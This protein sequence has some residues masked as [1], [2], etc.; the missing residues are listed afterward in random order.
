MKNSMPNEPPP[1]RASTSGATEQAEA[2]RT[3][4]SPASGAGHFELP[5]LCSPLAALGVVLGS[6]LLALLLTLARAPA[7]SDFYT[8]L[9]RAALLLLWT[10]LVCAALLCML[11]PRLARLPVRQGS[12]VAFGI[13]LAGVLVVT[14]AAYWLGYWLGPFGLGDH[15]FPSDHG[16]FLLRNLAI[17]A[18]VAAA[19]LRYLYVSQQWQGNVRRQA[20]A[21][22]HALQARIRPHFLFNSMNTIAS[23]TRSDPAAAEEAVEDLAELFRASLGD[24]RQQISIAEELEIC[25]VYERIERQRL[26]D[27]LQIDWRVSGLPLAAGIPSLTIQPLLENA[28]QHG[29]EPAREPSPIRVDGDCTGGAIRISISNPVAAAAKGS[30]RSGHGLGLA[31]VDERLQLAFGDKARLAIEE[32]DGRYSVTIRFPAVTAGEPK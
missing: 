17:G 20:E 29:I 32:A 28:I 4:V 5:D 24:G 6:Q 16:S 30:N 7:G 2:A 31:N 14:E 15:W 10:S 19:L 9:S 3:G 23:L 1:V 25:R 26:G 13:T 22:L 18:L 11:R 8:D 27:R 12:Y 21:R